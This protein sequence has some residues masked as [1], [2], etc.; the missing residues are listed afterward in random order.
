MI[1]RNRTSVGWL[2]AQ[3]ERLKRFIALSKDD[4]IAKNHSRSVQ[5]V[6][7]RQRSNPGGWAG[8]G[9]LRRFSPS[10]CA[11]AENSP[12]TT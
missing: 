3:A 9:S 6:V 11:W 10:I 2:T 5:T 4:P 12:H 7:A 8:S 1:I